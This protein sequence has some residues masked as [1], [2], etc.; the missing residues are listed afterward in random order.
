MRDEPLPS[1]REMVQYAKDT[2]NQTFESEEECFLDAFRHGEYHEEEPTLLRVSD[3]LSDQELASLY[4][5]ICQAMISGSVEHR[6]GPTLRVLMDCFATLGK[7]HR[8]HLS[9]PQEVLVALAKVRPLVFEE[10]L[11]NKG[12][13]WVGVLQHL[14][15]LETGIRRRMGITDLKLA[16]E[17]RAIEHKLDSSS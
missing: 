10:V 17:Y 16:G 5:P 12:T 6:E 3:R 11:A 13:W 2:W 9:D 1:F 8:K 15:M 4:L 14:E 7:W